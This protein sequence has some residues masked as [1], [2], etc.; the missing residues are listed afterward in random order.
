MY[1]ELS[2]LSFTSLNR[3]YH[4][5]SGSFA[6]PNLPDSTI[7]VP[8][9]KRPKSVDGYSL[10]SF[11]TKRLKLNLQSSNPCLQLVQLRERRSGG[12]VEVYRFICAQACIRTID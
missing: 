5:D 11:R 4:C 9:F 6:T 7:Y 1:V 12:R 8:F 10:F 2:H 3:L